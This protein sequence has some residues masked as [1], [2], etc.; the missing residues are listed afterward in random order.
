MFRL[1]LLTTVFS[2]LLLSPFA[3]CEEPS[4]K[5]PSKKGIAAKYVGDVGIEGNA[6]VIFAENFET[7]SLAE[8]A[9]RWG[10]ASNKNGKVQAFSPC[11]P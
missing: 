1:A 6:S 7:G 3:L 4:K 10:E 5:E 9:K 8:I 2:G 11:P